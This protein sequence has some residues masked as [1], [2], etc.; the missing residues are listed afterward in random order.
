MIARPNSFYKTIREREYTLGKRD[1]LGIQPLSED[2]HFVHVTNAAPR[3]GTSRRSNVLFWYACN[4]VRWWGNS[5]QEAEA[6]KKM[7]YV[8]GC[9]LF[10]N[11]DTSYFT[12][13]MLPGRP[14]LERFDPLPH[15]FLNHRHIGGIDTPWTVAIWQPV[16]E[17][18]TGDRICGPVRQ[19]RRPRRGERSVHRANQRLVPRQARIF[20][21][22][23]QKA[24]YRG[25]RQ[26]GSQVEHRRRRR[27]AVDFSRA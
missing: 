27:P 19:H 21:S 5:G 11:N 4:P 24:R 22:H 26:F 18:K 9:D 13:L 10:L 23:R 20:R 25:V 6:L 8:I 12:D 7:D 1:M 14:Y 16:V 15:M 3:N 17:A 2:G